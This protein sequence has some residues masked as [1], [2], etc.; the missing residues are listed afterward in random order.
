MNRL[1]LPGVQRSGHKNRLLG[2]FC[3]HR[4]NVDR[5]CNDRHWSSPVTTIFKA[6]YDEAMA[7]YLPRIVDAQLTEALGL[8]KVVRLYGP[9]GCGKTTTARQQAASAVD[10]REDDYIISP[11]NEQLRELLAGAR[12]RLIDE[13]A[14]HWRYPTDE[15]G[16]VQEPTKPGQFLLTAS[17]CLSDHPRWHADHGRVHPIRMRTMSLLETG[18]SSGA[19]SLR[20]LFDEPQFVANGQVVVD[21]EGFVTRLVIGGWPGRQHESCEAAIDGHRRWLHEY[22]ETRY[23]QKHHPEIY[24]AP[25]A[26]TPFAAYATVAA[27]AC[28]RPVRLE[29]LQ[30]RVGALA[31]RSTGPET[32]EWK[33]LVRFIANQARANFVHEWQQAWIP[34]THWPLLPDV[35]P[36]IHFADPSLIPAALNLN[37]E[38]L[39]TNREVFAITLRSQAV[40]DL[41]IY[42]QALDAR[43]VFQL[44]DRSSADH[45]EIVIQLRDR[46]WI[47]CQV[48]ADSGM[49]D[50]AAAELARVASKVQSPPTALAVITPIGKA[51][52][53]GDGIHVLPLAM[54]GP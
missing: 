4:K 35:A 28:T 19:I 3:H 46:R 42:A 8:S 21:L 34:Q 11:S 27:L 30:V 45:I 23:L 39:F 7:S 44:R 36:A 6:P 9:T 50:R 31:A 29:Q 49:V 47:G 52:T 48:V 43:G 17:T 38:Q 37:A 22:L 40:H 1:R 16:E 26:K 53:R 25:F 32:D 54:L 5:P 10:F 13:F 51:Y 15:H 18:H 24:E 14:N 20:A 41:K 2:E 33:W 12:P